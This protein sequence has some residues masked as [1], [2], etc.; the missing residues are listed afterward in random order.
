M[1]DVLG[2]FCEVRFRF[3][4]VGFLGFGFVFLPVNVYVY[5][6]NLVGLCFDLCFVP[7][8]FRNCLW[9][10]GFRGLELN[11]GHVVVPGLGR[12]RTRLL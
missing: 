6:Y 2:C 4:N 11:P 3:L 1:W 12:F 10:L 7:K 9:L 5:V 8:H